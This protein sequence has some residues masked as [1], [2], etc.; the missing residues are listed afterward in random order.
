[1]TTQEKCEAIVRRIVECANK[2]DRI[3]FE[4][5]C[6][7][8]TLT[9]LFAQG[10]THVGV[11]GGDFD[12]LVENLYNTLHGEPGL[13]WFHNVPESIRESDPDS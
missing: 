11:P 1:M 2:D 13:S 10:H 12:L 8:N 4:R 5:D 7:G 9:I 3:A 6:G